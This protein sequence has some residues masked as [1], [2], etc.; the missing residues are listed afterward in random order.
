MRIFIVVACLLFSTFSYA[1]GNH[2]GNLLQNDFNN[3]G[4]TM[5]SCTSPV[6]GR[7]IVYLV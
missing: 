1:N 3:L 7:D 2:R 4:P 6:T 5:K